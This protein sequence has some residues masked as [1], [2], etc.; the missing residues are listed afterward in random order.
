MTAQTINEIPDSWKSITDIPPI[1]DMISKIKSDPIFRDAFF[2]QETNNPENAA[3]GTYQPPVDFQGLMWETLDQ[4]DVIWIQAARGSA[5]SSGTARWLDG[6]CLVE[7]GTKAGV[8]APSFRQSKQFHDYCVYYMQSNF[9]ID[10]HIYKL[11]T[12]LA[13]DPIRGQEVLMKFKNSSYIEALPSGDGAKL[14]GKRFNV[15]VIEEAY[16]LQPEFH[17]QHILPMGNV[18]VGNRRTKTIYITTSW[19]T[20]VYAYTILQDI[21]RN[22]VKGVPGYAIIDIRLQDVLASGF[23]FDRKH[24]LHQL[25]ADSDRMTGKMSDDL[26]MTFF[27]V[28]IKS[29]ASFYTAGMIADCQRADVPVIEKKDEKDEIPTVLGVD[30]AT[31]GEDKCAMAVLGCP[32]KDQRYLRAVYQYSKLRVDEISG[33]IHKMVDLHGMKLILMDKTGIL[34][35]QIAEQAMK[36]RQLIDGLWQDRTPIYLWDHPDARLGRAHIVLTKPS[37]ER[38]KMAV[39]GRRYDETITGEIDLKNTLH[40]NM[41]RVLQN[42]LFYAPKMLK[43]EDYYISERGEIM[44]NIVEALSQFPK[45]DRKKGPDGKTYQQDNKGNYYFTRPAKDDGA[46]AIIYA[47]FCANIHYRLLEGPKRDEIPF[48]WGTD[49]ETQRLREQSNHQILMP[50]L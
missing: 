33:Y 34:G 47:N 15:I 10:S 31:T 27:N 11:E 32:G 24:I 16:Q 30:P 28:W 42:D 5:K 49:P 37:D 2:F 1:E 9:G 8:F 4:N 41:R 18:K 6:Y 50:R 17:K 12:E 7:P 35:I 13:A 43:D 48:L 29:G 45:I 3:D 46:Y 39:M 44:D 38:M 14:R 36:P 21:A 23:P 26:K 40:Y 19:Y 22:I 25:E 20:D